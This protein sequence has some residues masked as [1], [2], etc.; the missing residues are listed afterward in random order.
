MQGLLLWTFLRIRRDY[1]FSFIAN[2]QASLSYAQGVFQCTSY[3]S[4]F[5]LRIQWIGQ[6]GDDSCCYSEN[7]ARPPPHN[8]WNRKRGAIKAAETRKKEKSVNDLPSSE[9]KESKY[10]CG[11]CHTLQAFTQ[12]EEKWIGCDNCDSWYRFTCVGIC[13]STIPE[14]YYL[15]SDCSKVRFKWFQCQ[16]MF[17]ILDFFLSLNT[18]LLLKYWYNYCLE[19]FSSVSLLI[20]VDSNCCHDLQ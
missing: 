14:V 18:W 11:V 20:F 15:C 7:L 19:N 9:V 6:T 1:S 8:P 16:F 4:P 10:Q 17:S 3:M 5:R 12:A 13:D 2:L